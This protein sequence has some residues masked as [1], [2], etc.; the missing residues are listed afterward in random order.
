[1]IQGSIFCVNKLL[2]YWL[3]IIF[4]ENALPIVW[5]DTSLSGDNKTQNNDHFHT[6]ETP[7]GEMLSHQATS[8]VIQGQIFFLLIEDVSISQSSETSKLKVQ[9]PIIWHSSLITHQTN[10]MWVRPTFT[11]L[12]YKYNLCDSGLSLFKLDFSLRSFTHLAFHNIFK[13]KELNWLANNG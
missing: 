11:N 2:K 10:I 3:T 6:W 13:R 4:F 1:M 8:L 12:P 5:R 7:S 9:A